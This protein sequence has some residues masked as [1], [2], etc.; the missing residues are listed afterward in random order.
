MTGQL[1][2]GP[3]GP[4]AGGASPDDKGLGGSS[5]GTMSVDFSIYRLESPFCIWYLIPILYRLVDTHFFTYRVGGLTGPRMMY[6]YQFVNN[7]DTVII[8]I[9]SGSF[10]SSC[11]IFLCLRC[12]FYVL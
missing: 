7:D 12:I 2:L 8:Y 1:P 6:M 10:R 5:G 9:Y 3:G 4:L 11:V